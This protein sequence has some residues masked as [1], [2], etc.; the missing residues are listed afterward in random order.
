MHA[1]VP[2]AGDFPARLFVRHEGHA[3]IRY[4]IAEL[5]KAAKPAA[6]MHR[7]IAE[8]D[9]FAL[10][11]KK[12]RVHALIVAQDKDIA[13]R[14]I[15]R[16]FEIAE[17]EPVRVLP[18]A[19]DALVRKVFVSGVAAHSARIRVKLDLST[20]G[21]RIPFPIAHVKLQPVAGE[22]MR[23]SLRIDKEIHA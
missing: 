14:R 18:D 7:D 1:V 8:G 12:P 4:R 15:H 10:F 2:P 5:R 22:A 17:P 11:G 13:H 6:G 3:L 16:L 20:R 9:V 19:F 23:K 21:Q